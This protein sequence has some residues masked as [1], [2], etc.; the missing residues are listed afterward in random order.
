MPV[1]AGRS[2]SKFEDLYSNLKGKG[3]SRKVKKKKK[4]RKRG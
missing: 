4:K 3:K 1:P 2:R